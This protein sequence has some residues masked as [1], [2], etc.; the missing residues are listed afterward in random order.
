ML[1]DLQKKFLEYYQQKGN[2]RD[3]LVVYEEWS[4]TPQDY[5]DEK[6]PARFFKDIKEINL[7]I[8]M[9]PIYTHDLPPLLISRI[10]N[11]KTKAIAP[12]EKVALDS[13]LLNNPEQWHTVINAIYLLGEL[14]YSGCVSA[15]IKATKV[16]KSQIILNYILDAF[17]KIKNKAIPILIKVLRQEEDPETK[18]RLAWILA[19]LKQ[20]DE[21]FLLLKEL[22]VKAENKVFWADLLADYGE[23]KATKI[24]QT[25]AVKERE[26]LSYQEIDAIERAL[27]LLGGEWNWKL[28]ENFQAIKIRKMLLM[29]TEM[30]L[31]PEGE[32]IMGSEEGYP[33]EK[34]CHKVTLP[35]FYMD[36]YP[37]TIRQYRLFQQA[38]GY[39]SES[40]KYRGNDYPDDHPVVYVSWKDAY[41][42]SSWLGKRLPTEA[43]WEKSARGV[44]GR[45]WPWGNDWDADKLNSLESRIGTTTPVNKYPKGCSP[46]GVMDMAGNAQEWTSSPELPYPY[47]DTGE[48]K[49]I[50]RVLRGGSH[51]MGKFFTRCS[52]RNRGGVDGW[53]NDI[54]FRCAIGVGEWEKLMEEIE[55]Q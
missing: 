29:E 32:F 49:S 27:V 7:L 16:A 20:D 55:D 45:I 22:L 23:R 40:D 21:V 6:T 54:G 47:K 12:L 51:H 3:P 2:G 19:N 1:I 24:L 52:Y 4:Q 10:R 35:A 53:A 43:E 48:N 17:S 11:F 31:I 42:Y 46:Y 50:I 18:A 39:H 41:A 9:L 34:P 8:K 26:K 38:T 37:V 15:L 44:D 28:E 5:L 14:R 13:N 33:N 30:V 36:R 25:L